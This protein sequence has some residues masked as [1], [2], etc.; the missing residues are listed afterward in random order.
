MITKSRTE[1]FGSEV[2]RRI[3][4]GTFAL[5]RKSYESYY[6]KALEIRRLVLNDFKTVF[7]SKENP[8]GV[9][10]L[11]TPTAPSS[12]GELKNALEKT[13]Q[14]PVDL[15]LMDVM[16]IPANMAGIPAMSVPYQLSAAN[17]PVGLQLMSNYFEEDLLFKVGSF[18]EKPWS[19]KS[20]NVLE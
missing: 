6:K 2:Q 1:G 7:R 20:P 11:L 18:L 10:V 19:R 12:A 3:I 9:D 5:S 8:S 15:Y 17:L 14:N 16:T 13:K 4:V